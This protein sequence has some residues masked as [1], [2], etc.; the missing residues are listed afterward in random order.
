MHEVLISLHNTLASRIALRYAKQ[1]EGSDRFNM[2]A[3]HI[4]GIKA[5]G[6]APGGGWVKEKWENA[7]AEDASDGISDLIRK[8]Y[9]FHFSDSGLKT[10]FGPEDQVILGELEDRPYDFFIEGQLHAFDPAAFKTRLSS[11]LFR[12]TACPVLMVKNM[13][14]P[15]RGTL[16]LSPVRQR[17]SHPSAWLTKLLTGLPGPLDSLSCRFD[18]GE[19]DDFSPVLKDPDINQVSETDDDSWEGINQAFY[20]R[21]TPEQLAGWASRYSLVVAPLPSPQSRLA[22]VLAAVST[23]VMLLPQPKSGQEKEH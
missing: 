3:I 15:N 14:N 23:A 10:V 1:M 17:V 21:G 20:G 19:K 9:L 6:P 16:I 13:V 2:Q 7:L 18:A 5:A 12:K 4:P 22:R 8:E 11:R